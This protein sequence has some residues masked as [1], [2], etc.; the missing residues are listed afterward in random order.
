MKQKLEL[1]WIGKE[2]RPR[3][4]PRILLEDASKS[5]HAK[6]RVSANDIF[7]NRL[8]YGDNLLALKAL[9]QEF[10]GKI[11]CIF[12][13]PPY[14]TGSAFTQ[15]DDGVEHSLW[16]SLMR[17]RIELLR[18]LLSDEGSLWITIDDNECHYLKVLC[19]EVFGRANY[20]TSIV[21]EKDKGRRSDTAFSVSHDY[22]LIYAKSQTAWVKTRNLL[23]RS[24]D[25]LKRYRNPDHDPRGPWL[26]GDNGTAKS[27]SEGSRFPVTLPSGRVVVP[28]PSR[29]WS[30]SKA[31]LELARSENRV[32]FGA[33]GDGMPIIKRYLS[34]VQGGVVPRTWW[35]ADEA[36]HNQEAKRDH[37][38]K[39]LKDVE[40]FSTPKPERLL[41]KILTI[42]TNTGDL[43]T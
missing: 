11:K 37:L 4:E 9:E 35:S 26:Q 18:R 12:I 41:Q 25:Q 33:D 40:P 27:A 23:E 6:T 15:F 39:L 14:N 22:I 2:N 7:D 42:S 36:G 19:D 16:L 1:T 31:T 8:I 17:D 20:V 5:Y 30:F 34:E 38:N 3:L 13:D 21:W 28:P 32:Y 43:V 24:E 10:A 29:G